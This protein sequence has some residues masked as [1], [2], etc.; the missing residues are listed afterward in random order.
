MSSSVSVERSEVRFGTKTIEYSIKRSSRRGTVSI[1]IDPN[2]GV[3][4]TAPSPAPVKRLDEIV[5]AKATWIVQRLKRQSD[6]APCS[7]REFVSGETFLYLGR[8]YRLRLDRDRAPRPLRLDNGWLRVPLPRHLGE[9]HRGSFVRAALID[10]Y[11]RHASKRLRE[12]LVFWCAKFD[13]DAP[14]MLVVEP[15]K[16]W[17]SASTSGTVRLNW[18]IIQAPVSLVDYVV[19]HE[20]THL[21]HPNHTPDFWAALGRV[22]PDY[23]ARKARL[24]AM[25]ARLEW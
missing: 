3:L 24:R 23:D 8:Q 10:W 25:G 19:A 22:M 20:L 9:E 12:R 13:L 6:L 2:E 15:R 1:A 17:G 18:R 16:R 11:N 5:H 4:V 21:R 7:E 14:E